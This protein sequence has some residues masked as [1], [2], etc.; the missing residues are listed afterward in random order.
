MA[1]YESLKRKQTAVTDFA[2]EASAETV[3]TATGGIIEASKTCSS[4]SAMG[5]IK[6]LPEAITTTWQRTLM[7][8]CVVHPIRSPF[9]DAGRG[10]H[11]G[12]VKVLTPV[13]TAP[14][15]RFTEFDAQ[16][17]QRYRRST[18]CVERGTRQ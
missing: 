9:R 5:S 13:H 3:D 12:I 15:D 18:D 6:G 8:Q 16:W 1:K 17:S 11:G 7:Q 14:C 4:P 2:A 10:H